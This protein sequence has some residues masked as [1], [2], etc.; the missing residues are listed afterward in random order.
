[1]KYINMLL[2]ASYH[3]SMYALYTISI[4]ISRNC[5]CCLL[6]TE[7][8]FAGQFAYFDVF[9]PQ[10]PLGDDLA[11]FTIPIPLPFGYANDKQPPVVMLGL[12]HW[13]FPDYIP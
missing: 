5:K 12:W 2:L 6:V 11:V 7:H 13:F 10:Q 3:S 8:G 4:D 1:M 9:F